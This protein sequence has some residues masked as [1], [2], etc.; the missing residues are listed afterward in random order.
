[1]LVRR[2]QR[3]AQIMDREVGSLGEIQPTVLLVGLDAT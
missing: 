2:P 1:M 3:D